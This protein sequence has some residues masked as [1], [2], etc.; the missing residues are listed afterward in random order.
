MSAGTDAAALARRLREHAVGSL[1][2]APK[3]WVGA[4]NG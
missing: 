4:D 1:M 3:V 2:P